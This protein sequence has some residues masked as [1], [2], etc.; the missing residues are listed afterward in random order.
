VICGK[1]TSAW[2]TPPVWPEG[3]SRDLTLPLGAFGDSASGVDLAGLK[4]RTR[5]YVASRGLSWIGGHYAGVDTSEGEWP[6]A[7]SLRETRAHN[8]FWTPPVSARKAGDFSSPL[9]IATECS[10]ASPA[11]GRRP[12]RQPVMQHGKRDPPFD[13]DLAM[14]LNPPTRARWGAK[15]EVSIL[16]ALS[17]WRFSSQSITG[18]RWPRFMRRTA[19]DPRRRESLAPGPQRP[20]R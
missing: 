10:S 5:G 3:G 11:L 7:C 4:N 9:P 2:D 14:V 17:G 13:V 8:F 19:R 20:F 18:T 6:K 1:K 15:P 16:Q 12:F